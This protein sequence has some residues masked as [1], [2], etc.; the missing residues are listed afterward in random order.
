MINYNQPLDIYRHPC[1][2]VKFNLAVQNILQAK[3]VHFGKLSQYEIIGGLSS[4]KIN[5]NFNKGVSTP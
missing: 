2:S 3:T 5:S 4:P 1:S